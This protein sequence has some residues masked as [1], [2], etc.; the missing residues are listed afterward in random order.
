MAA[1][2]STLLCV[3]GQEASLEFEIQAQWTYT[4]FVANLLESAAA[5]NDTPYELLLGAFIGFG[6]EAADGDPEM[7]D[8]AIY[9]RINAHLSA[10]RRDYVNFDTIYKVNSPRIAEH[11][12]HF[13]EKYGGDQ[14]K[15]L[16]KICSTDSFGAR[17]PFV[18][19]HP[20]AFL[21]YN[22]KIYCSPDDVYALQIGSSSDYQTLPFDRI[23]GSYENAPVLVLY[24]IPGAS[25]THAFLHHL[26][27]N[28]QG[29][30]LRFVWRYLGDTE[31]ADPMVGYGARLQF[32][33]NTSPMRPDE[34]C[35]HALSGGEPFQKYERLKALLRN[36][37]EIKPGLNSKVKN[38]FRVSQNNNAQL[39]LSSASTGIYVNGAIIPKAEL[40]VY[41]L[42]SKIKSEV[43]RIA[44]LL[45]LGLS[46]I[47]ARTL[48][49]KFALLS[50]VKDS[51]YQK[52]NSVMGG[53]ENRFPVYREESVIFFNNIE[54]DKNYNDYSTNAKEAY[55]EV[56][57]HLRVGQIPP[58]KENVHDLIFVVNPSSTRQLEVFFTL[59][60]LILD[61][62]IPQQIGILPLVDNDD[63]QKLAE[64]VYFLYQSASAQ[65]ALGFLYK[66]YEAG[67]DF[68][69]LT[70]LLDTVTIPND[71]QIPSFTDTTKRFSL[72]K[73]SVIVNGAIHDMAAA[74]WQTTMV[75][76][77]SQDV[78]ILKRH[79]QTESAPRPLKELLYENSSKSRNLR[80]APEKTSSIIYK[81][82][83]EDLIA[84]S[85]AIK[86]GSEHVNL[87][88]NVWLIGDYSTVRA[89]QQ[90]RIL[91]QFVKSEP[92]IQ[93]NTVHTGLDR[94]F[95]AKIFT[96]RIL[97]SG[98]LSPS[99][100]NQALSKISELL[101]TA[102]DAPNVDSQV[103]SMLERNGLP[104]AYTYLLY[105][106]RFFR[107]DSILDLN[108]M[109]HL[110]KHDWNQRISIISDVV[111]AYEDIFDRKSLTDFLPESKAES[112]FDLLTSIITTLYYKSEF[113]T[114]GDASRFD[115]SGLDYGNAINFV[116][117]SAVEVLVIAD[118]GEEY[119]QPLVEMVEPLLS[120]D[121]V[122][123]RILL[124]TAIEN[125]ASLPQSSYGALHPVIK[126]KFKEG[127]HQ[128]ESSSILLVG[129]KGLS[130][131]FSIDTPFSWHVVQYKSSED[132]DIQNVST[133]KSQWAVFQ[134]KNLLVDGY[135][136]DIGTGSSPHNA[137]LEISRNKFAQDTSILGALGYFQFRV[138]P[139]HYNL[140][141]K[142][143]RNSY[144][145]LSASKDFNSSREVLDEIPI[146]VYS[147]HG[148][149]LSVRLQLTTYT[150]KHAKKAGLREVRYFDADIDIFTI[151][152]GDQYERLVSIMFASVVAHTRK[153][154]KF[155]LLEE[156][157][158]AKF[159]LNLPVLAAKLGFK[160]EFVS[161]KWP[162]W[163]R[164]Q[165]LVRRTVWGYKIL[166]LD[167]LFPQD[168]TRVIFIDADQVLRADLMELMAVDLEGAPY[169]FTPMC[170]SRQDMAGFH[171]WK[172]GYWA[173]LL[174]D[175]LKYHISAMFVVDLNEF[176]K[177]RVGDILRSHYQRLSSDP[178]SLL[179]LDQDLPNNL[180]RHVPIHSLPKEWLWCP[181]WCAEE[182]LVTAKAIDLCDDPSS[183]ENKI[184]RARRVIKEWNDYD[185]KLEL[186]LARTKPDYFQRPQL[187]VSGPFVPL[188]AENAE[189]LDY[190]HDEL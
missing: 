105:N 77:L 175:D 125:E 4:P 7:S 164:S 20:H 66:C 33:D 43:A 56:S 91:L 118:P 67:E 45:K 82:V 42:V 115:F 177:R 172:E 35:M 129:L 93:V 182:E 159:K 32:P 21:V 102:L 185:R 58:L 161:Y 75:N 92:H 165:H 25:S 122:D 46:T 22:N 142:S 36:P 189:D 179:N 24:G 181:T 13:E 90:L 11:Y 173:K 101:K 100:C 5:H 141:S 149:H 137:L 145:L 168:L 163:L 1:L 144:G 44:Q 68:G 174:Q 176:K 89:L 171:F 88:S 104:L 170:E 178:S 78:M 128:P 48:L 63:D 26:M 126:P 37:W 12:R 64:V 41:S 97:S 166:F 180:Q 146:Q 72:E 186:I 71:F 152:S 124:H 116:T 27:A 54:L 80:V 140:C 16:E 23:V 70:E 87:P 150:P 52:G 154:P 94:N 167:V 51:Q 120:F 84:N 103:Q 15:K 147:L 121:D 123:V 135:V 187:P 117:G 39:G 81:E 69:K 153:V 96:S 110:V 98:K 183:N 162:I 47:Q 60:K 83:T 107:L 17:V 28:A 85:V 40:S 136:K 76:Q 184:D 8:V 114:L 95:L 18:E 112:W 31:A 160:Y 57:K 111:D 2:I 38:A 30:K 131:R 50:A 99:E 143:A 138:L 10:E 109:K 14:L 29:G 151:A 86:I 65:E 158:S 49:T 113:V 155:W 62:G 188:D 53:N 34:L 108:D 148:N 61:R 106:S 9:G 139:G 132:L 157:L 190:S 6:D 19:G 3:H 169:G 74:G 119:S 130:G 55:L 133:S 73:P 134:L 59:A 156:F 79:L 127:R